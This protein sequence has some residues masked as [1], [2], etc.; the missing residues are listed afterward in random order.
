ML[1]EKIFG[2]QIRAERKR[3]KMTQ[4][5]LGKVVDISV[6]YLSEI[7]RGLADNISGRVRV[8][9]EGFLF[10][11]KQT[12][13]SVVEQA[14]TTENYGSDGET[15]E[16]VPIYNMA[17][18]GIGGSEPEW[19]EPICQRAI[20][21]KFMRPGL[22][23]VMVNG[24][25]MEPTMKDGAVVGVDC[26]DKRVVSGEAYAVLIPHEG[27]V[28]KRLYL[29]PTGVLLR[30][31]NKEFPEFTIPKD[32]LADHFVLGRVRWVVQEM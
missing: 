20:Q 9:L 22:R 18:A 8:A 6:P 12:C 15:C 4:A 24:R 17:T 30:S 14:G 29:L 1:K 16:M 10:G 27:A 11:E 26:N 19:A 31:D 3:R 13:V 28:I 2:E 32:D 21:T 7:E 5:D 23:P 25:S